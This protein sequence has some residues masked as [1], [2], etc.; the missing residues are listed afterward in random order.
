[1]AILFKFQSIRFTIYIYI[2]YPFII[3]INLINNK[4][5][6]LFLYD[7]FS[8]KNW[9]KAFQNFNKNNLEIDQG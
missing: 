3:A 6:Q 1:M 7:L 2:F 5:V 4:N 9:P 8:H